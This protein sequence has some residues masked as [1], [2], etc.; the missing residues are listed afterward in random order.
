[1]PT[2]WWKATCQDCGKQGNSGMSPNLNPPPGRPEVP[3]KCEASVTGKHRPIWV[4]VR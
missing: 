2:T 4:Q 1:M 3:G